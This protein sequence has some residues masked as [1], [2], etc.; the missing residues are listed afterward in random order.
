M[1]GVP[2]CSGTWGEGALGSSGGL[3][4]GG[5]WLECCWRSCGSCRAGEHCVSAEA[6][7]LVRL[8]AGGRRRVASLTPDGGGLLEPLVMFGCWCGWC[9]EVLWWVMVSLLQGFDGV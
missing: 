1:H 4:L 5:G 9:L 7:C 8:M 2:G 6:V 3:T